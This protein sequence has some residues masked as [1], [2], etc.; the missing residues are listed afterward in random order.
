MRRRDFWSLLRVALETTSRKAFIGSF[1]AMQR[2]AVEGCG[3]PN[4]RLHAPFVEISKSEIVKI[5]AG[6]KVPFEETWSCYEGGAIHCGRCGT[7][8]ERKESF[9]NAG[10]LDPTAYSA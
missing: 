9:E 4:L 10:V 1:D 8:V 2:L 7:C 6:L 3:N 5:G